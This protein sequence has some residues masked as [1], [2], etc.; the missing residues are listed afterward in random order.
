[1]K[2]ANELRT[3][4]T[5]QKVAV[6]HALLKNGGMKKRK[7][8]PGAKITA[9]A[10]SANNPATGNKGYTDFGTNSADARIA[11]AQAAVHWNKRSELK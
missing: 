9:G 3:T 5:P 11:A 4:G 10:E 2:L 7:P 8:R 1:M 6:E